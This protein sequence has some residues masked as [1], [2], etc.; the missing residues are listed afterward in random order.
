MI[1]YTVTETMKS[2]LNSNS[3]REKLERTISL[4]LSDGQWKVLEDLESYKLLVA[5][6]GSFQR[7]LSDCTETLAAF[8][9]ATQVAEVTSPASGSLSWDPEDD[10]DR[11]SVDMV[12]ASI[13]AARA[14]SE[15]S[16]YIDAVRAWREGSGQSQTIE[17]L[18]NSALAEFFDGEK[19]ISSELAKLREFWLAIPDPEPDPQDG[20]PSRVEESIVNW[21]AFWSAVERQA[22]GVIPIYVP[23]LQTVHHIAYFSDDS[24]VGYLHHVANEMSLSRM[25][26]VS[27][28]AAFIL[29]DHVPRVA[30]SQAFWVPNE[31]LPALSR[32]VLT[33]D[34]TLSPD[35]VR[36]IYRAERRKYSKY[37]LRISNKHLLATFMAF[38]DGEVTDWP[39]A[40]RKHKE[41]VQTMPGMEFANAKSFRRDTIK[42]YNKL[43]KPD[44]G[45]S[46]DD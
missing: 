19:P 21:D 4:T 11:E 31:S 7:W 44:F 36:E 23:D 5:R 42:G 1:P 18:E 41:S 45:R 20:E 15:H 32:I 30:S 38:R 2:L 40:Y 17:N 25:W 33:L 3:Y 26:Q 28:A 34:P 10:A 13:I 6:E 27:E 8:G 9:I 14:Y 29:F 24:V 22:K 46:S 39:A 43:I 12:R 16:A 37:P 35:E